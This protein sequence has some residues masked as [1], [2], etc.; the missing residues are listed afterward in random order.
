[1][2]RAPPRGYQQLALGKVFREH[3]SDD[4]DL[5]GQ[6]KRL[7]DMLVGGLRENHGEG[8]K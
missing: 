3:T 1:M 4:G 8:V 5:S 7:H 6:V 2:P